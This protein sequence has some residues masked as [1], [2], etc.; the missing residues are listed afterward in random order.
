MQ[1]MRID[2]AIIPGGCTGLIQ[3]ADVNWNRSVKIHFTKNYDCWLADG[4]HSYTA[5][6]N[7]KP[8]SFHTIA[9]WIKDAWEAIPSSQIVNSMKHC[10]IVVAPDGSEVREIKCFKPGHPCHCAVDLPRS[11]DT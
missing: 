11:S 1:S 3:P 10:R 4:M 8:P 9:S 2:S 7:M 5:R 6:G